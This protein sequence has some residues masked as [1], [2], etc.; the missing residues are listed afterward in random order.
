MIKEIL[1]VG[2]VFG[3]VALDGNISEDETAEAIT[4]NCMIC[5]FNSTE[6]KK[7]VQCNPILAMNYA[8]QVSRKLRRLENRHSNLVFKDA[9]TRLL[10]FF[11]DWANREGNRAGDKIILNNYLTHNDI[12]GIISTSRQSVTTL[13]N[14]LRD[15]GLLLY[16]RKRIEIKEAGMIN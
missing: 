14:E 9:K 15:T 13:L 12:A 7:I 16:N 10:S 8:A 4:D 1:S 11:K 3:D 2:E 5:S 6:F